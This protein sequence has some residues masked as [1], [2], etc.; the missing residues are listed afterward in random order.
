MIMSSY[1]LKITNSA[2]TATQATFSGTSTLLASKESS[3]II[4][5]DA[6]LHMSGTK[7]LFANLSQLYDIRSVA[8]VD[9]RF[10]PVSDEGV[11]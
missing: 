11:V 1:E 2:A 7:N 10:C 8:I 4:D 9:D 5:S 3:W 6:S